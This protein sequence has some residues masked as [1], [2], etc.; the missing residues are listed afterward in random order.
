MEPVQ[1]APTADTTNT[2]SPD[3]GT[4]DVSSPG[5]PSSFT[6]DQGKLGYVGLAIIGVTLAS[7]FYS[8][9]WYRKNI[10][11]MEEEMDENDEIRKEVAEIKVNL[12]ALLGNRYQSI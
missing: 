4:I 3:A 11:I 8:I 1:A 10:R 12:K 6:D 9:Y 5:V 2:P 7:L